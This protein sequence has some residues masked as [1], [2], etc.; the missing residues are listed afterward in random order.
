M[1]GKKQDEYVPKV[2]ITMR[3]AADLAATMRATG[4]GWQPRAEEVL[5]REYLTEKAQ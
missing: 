5:K 1:A 3:V 2:L 4:P